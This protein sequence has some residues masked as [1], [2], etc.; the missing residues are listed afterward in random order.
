MTNESASVQPTPYPQWLD[1]VYQTGAA[2]DL[3]RGW[4]TSVGPSARQ[5]A[6]L[7]LFGESPEGGE[8]VVL[9][10][11][12]EDMR[13]HPGQVSFPGGGVEGHDASR[14]A[15]ALREAEEEIALD[16]TGVHV[17]GEMAP[18]PLTVTN[19]LVTPVVAW[20]HTPSPIRAADPTEVA[21]VARVRVADLVDP[22]NRFTATHPRG[23]AGPAFDV[24]GFY[25]WGFTAFI[26]DAVLTAGG[27]SLPWDADDRRQVPDR[28]LR[29]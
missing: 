29:R 25:I 1:T 28:F 20:W 9:T 15:T 18:I 6:I 19:F 13:K 8:D 26:L 16:G 27:Q 21:R 10:Q 3:M 2:G 12:A 24:D 5:S 7:L 4:R 23:Y 14:T 11:R 17:L 22:N